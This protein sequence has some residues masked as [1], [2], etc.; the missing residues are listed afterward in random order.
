M[1]IAGPWYAPMMMNEPGSGLQVRGELHEV[2]DPRLALLDRLESVGKPG[3]YRVVIEVE[4]LVGTARWPAFAYVKSR[5]VRP[6]FIPTCWK[7]TM[8]TA[9]CRSID[10]AS[11]PR[12]GPAWPLSRFGFAVPRRPFP[13][14]RFHLQRSRGSF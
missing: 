3:N 4:A 14:D 9:S 7:T 11:R 2:D 6:P 1:F 5:V 12:D 13:G 8:T 10:A